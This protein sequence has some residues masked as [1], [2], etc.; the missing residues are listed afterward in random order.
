MD[1]LCRFIITENAPVV[2]FAWTSSIDFR[3]RSRFRRAEFFF[4]WEGLSF[5]PIR[6]RYVD[7]ECT[8]N[9]SAKCDTRFTVEVGLASHRD[10]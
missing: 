3:A 8:R 1:R 6:A 4:R 5:F 2:A 9:L 7:V 10:G